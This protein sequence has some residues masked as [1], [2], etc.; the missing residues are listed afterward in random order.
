MN[1]REATE[2][3]PS[4]ID[5]E[6]DNQRISVLREHLS[7]CPSCREELQA[8]ARTW[9]M[10]KV[11]ADEEPSPGYVSRFWT[12]V[13]REEP[14]YEK[15]WEEIKFFFADKRIAPVIATACLILLVG[16]FTFY[17]SFFVTKTETL[18]SSLSADEME[19]VENIELV[20]QFDIIANIELL[21]DLDVIENLDNLEA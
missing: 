3:F 2:L 20:E 18:L 11:W 8:Y 14:F 15:A 12:R 1:C 13:A 9:D 4:F 5:R 6:L 17:N 7:H 21:E 16:S 19:F 10:L